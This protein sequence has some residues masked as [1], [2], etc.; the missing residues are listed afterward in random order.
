MTKNLKVLAMLVLGA[1]VCVGVSVKPAAAGPA[2][3]VNST[4]AFEKLRTLAGR[5]EA[6]SP[7]GKISTSYELVSGGT[8]L[9]E[10]M[11]VPGKD[12]MVT[13]YHLDGNHL[14]LEHYCMAGNQP[15]MQARAFRPES[16]ELDF[17]FVSAT[18]LASAGAGHM[19]QLALRFS[20][21]AEFA[22]D[23]TWSENGKI[24]GHNVS[25]VYH[26][27]K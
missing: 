22:A 27:V 1:G 13:T 10:R 3:A 15:H 11:E 25:L 17:D 20:S 26:R 7:M 4:A 24:G 14:L 8:V 12:P 23:W 18:N 16:S 6:T 19:H 5:W 9:L 2:D 21:A